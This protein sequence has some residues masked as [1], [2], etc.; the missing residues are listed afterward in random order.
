MRRKTVERT[1]GVEE[2]P[3]SK[4]IWEMNTADGLDDFLNQIGTGKWSYLFFA[5]SAV[6][7]GLLPIYLIGSEFLNA[8]PSYSCDTAD[9]NRTRPL[10]G[11]QCWMIEEDST[12]HEQIVPCKKWIYDTSVFQSTI[13]MEWN[14]VCDRA[15]LSPFFQTIYT[16]GCFLGGILGAITA[17]RYGRRWSVKTGTLLTTG[18]TVLLVLSRWFWLVM[19]SRFFLGVSNTIMVYPS[20]INSMEICQP[21]LRTTVG[22]F[23]AL[24]YALMMIGLSGLAYWIRDWRILQAAASWP[25]LV[26]LVLVFLIDESP[27]WLIVRGRLEEATEVLQRA[28]RLNRPNLSQELD[29]SALVHSMYQKLNT[30][31]TQKTRMF[32]AT[33]GN[34]LSCSESFNALGL[35]DGVGPWW[36]G[37]MA[38]LRTKIIRKVTLVLFAVWLLQGIVYLGLPLSS[39][40]FSSP[41]L[42]M[43]LLGVFEIPAYTLT[44]PITKRLGRKSVVITCLVCCGALLI[45]VT[46]LLLADLKNEWIHIAIVMASYLLIC[47]AYQVNFLYAPELFPTTLRPWGTA[48][49]GLSAY[50]GFS[51][52]PFITDYVGSEHTWVPPAV[53]GCCS[54]IAGLLLFLLPETNGRRL[55]ET[56]ADLM[57][58]LEEEKSRRADVIRSP[59]SSHLIYGSD[60]NAFSPPIVSTI[61]GGQQNGGFS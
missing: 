36:A 48:V 31:Q 37:P 61:S 58:R 11:S 24:P 10:N 47:T 26:L 9:S 12:G 7:P 3:I 20:F 1:P 5:V 34:A 49:C 59:S 13:T 15:H 32:S 8:V 39:S 30:P 18:F 43:A 38:L 56:V 28:V 21:S 2:K 42:Y 33:G 16:A 4:R 55:P 44:A 41:F 25:C 22:I 14:L 53:F 57:K 54:A 45:S 40:S 23:L 29:V 52:P 50:V 51:I 60:N 17:N 35:D 27:R 19:L 46:G 6:V